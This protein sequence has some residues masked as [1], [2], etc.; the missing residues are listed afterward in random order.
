M[1]DHIWHPMRY[2]SNAQGHGG[3]F[4]EIMVMLESGFRSLGMSIPVVKAPAPIS[5]RPLII[6]GPALGV[7]PRRLRRPPITLS[8]EAVVYNHEQIFPGTWLLNDDYLFALRHCE[9]WDYSQVNIEAF[10][11][12]GIAPVK[13]VPN[14]YVPELEVF[15]Q[16]PEADKD[17]DVLFVGGSFPRRVKI[18]DECRKLGLRVTHLT[19]CYGAARDNFHARAKVVLNLHAYAAAI[20]ETARVSYLLANGCCVVSENGTDQQ[21]EDS[22][23]AGVTFG[24]A[25]EVPALALRLVNDPAARSKQAAAGQAMMR[26]MRFD[27]IL[28]KALA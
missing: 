4:G 22:Y 20:F 5:E 24:S 1:I 19:N 11:K 16:K 13:H 14:G 18:L 8:D 15:A 21:A 17:I 27:G 12:M 10:R 6:C 26:K 9:V 28:S 3:V 23:R 2:A 25:E 7:L